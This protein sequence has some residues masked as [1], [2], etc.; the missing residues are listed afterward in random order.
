VSRFRW[1]R[2]PISDVLHSSSAQNANI[3]SASLGVTSDGI[4]GSSVRVREGF[5]TRVRRE[6]LGRF[7]TW[8]VPTDDQVGDWRDLATAV[9][10]DKD[11]QHRKHTEG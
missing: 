9:H 3:A 1:N 2:L 6:G 8:W 7:R 11:I 5:P 4:R 10:R